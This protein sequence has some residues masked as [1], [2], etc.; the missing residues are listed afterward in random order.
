MIVS[1]HIRIRAKSQGMALSLGDK[2]NTSQKS[3]SKKVAVAVAT[4]PEG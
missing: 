3:R 4:D 2:I 1:G